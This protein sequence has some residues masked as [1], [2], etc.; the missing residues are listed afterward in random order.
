MFNACC[1]F[2]WAEVRKLSGGGEGDFVASQS[3]AGKCTLKQPLK[4]ATHLVILYADR[5]DRRKS[6]GVPGAAIAI[7]SIGAI[8]L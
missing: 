4:P 6:L 5:R 7:L 2:F 3:R 8:G 1:I